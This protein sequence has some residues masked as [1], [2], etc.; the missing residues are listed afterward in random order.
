MK[1]SIS[2]LLLLLITSL[3]Y[4]QKLVFSMRAFG[5]DVGRMT[6]TRSVLADSTEVITMNSDGQVKLLWIDRKDETRHEVRYKNGKMVSSNYKHYQNGKLEKWCTISFDGKVYQVASNTGKRTMA[7][8]PTYSIASL[9]FHSPKNIN[10]VFYEA[11]ASYSELK[12]PDANTVDFKTS[13][14][15]RNIYKY[16]NGSLQEMEFKLSIATVSMKRIQ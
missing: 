6:V 15:N 4:S 10:R 7:E 11:D 5:T 8:A 14:G 12:H 13:E 2:I 1:K 16:V 9:Y 3:G